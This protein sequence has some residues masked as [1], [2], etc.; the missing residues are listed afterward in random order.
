M[1][2]VIIIGQITTQG[3]VVHSLTE[4]PSP[5]VRRCMGMQHDIEGER[6]RDLGQQ[7]EMRFMTRRVSSS[8]A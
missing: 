4:L 1:Y 7:R 3:L 6:S 5:P 2:P 8:P